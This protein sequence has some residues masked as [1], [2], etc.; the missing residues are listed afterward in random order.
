MKLCHDGAIYC[1][2]CRRSLKTEI[3]LRCKKC[4][5]DSKWF[6]ERED[7]HDSVTERWLLEEFKAQEERGSFYI[8]FDDTDVP[9]ILRRVKGY[10]VWSAFWGDKNS[11]GGSF[12]FDVHA[13]CQVRAI[14]A[15]MLL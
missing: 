9:L 3:R 7:D 8:Y 6:G 12:P 1:P 11:R 13:R 2:H 10:E 15:L 4:C 14:I 5:V